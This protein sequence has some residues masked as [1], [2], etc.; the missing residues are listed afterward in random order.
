[1]KDFQF[2]QKFVWEKE[3]YKPNYGKLTIE[4]LIRGYGITVGNALRRVLLSSLWGVAVTSLKV[5]GVFHEFTKV[6]GIKEDMVEV[7][8]NVK[9]IKL[10]ANIS[11]FPHVINTVIEKSGPVT[12]ADLVSDSG[13]EVLNGNLHIMTLTQK[14]K[15]SIDIEITEGRG[16]VSNESLK[17]IKGSVPLGSMLIDGLY[18]PVTKVLYSVENILYKTSHDYERL[19]L[20]VFTTGA[21]APL[22]AVSEATGII[23]SHFNLI[24]E[25]QTIGEKEA[26]KEAEESKLEVAEGDMHISEIIFPTRVNNVLKKL[27]IKTITELLRMPREELEGIKNLGKKS[28]EEIDSIL[29]EKGF[30]LKSKTELE[31]EAKNET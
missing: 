22:D 23:N 24:E 18:S 14:K 11:D 25:H 7:I 16:Y 28:I 5:E 21:I 17:R 12:A 13:L 31:Q 29:V 8:M 30:K 10:K 15:F 1:M 6:E 4:P 3:T 2:P 27:G 20:E 26:R 19:T 9:Q